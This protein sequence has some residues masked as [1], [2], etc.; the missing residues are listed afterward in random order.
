[1]KSYVFLLFKI[2]IALK[3]YLVKLYLESFLFL[4]DFPGSPA[5]AAG[6]LYPPP[7]QPAPQAE[8]RDVVKKFERISRNILT[9]KIYL[10]I[11]VSR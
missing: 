2:R 11:L 8:R 6:G 10:D 1:L 3:F 5:P 4:R 7:G 9:I